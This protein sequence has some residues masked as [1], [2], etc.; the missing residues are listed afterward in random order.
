MPSSFVIGILFQD[1][2]LSYFPNLSSCTI[3]PFLEG[4]FNLTQEDCQ[5]YQALPVQI[6]QCSHPTILISPVPDE[7]SFLL[8]LILFLH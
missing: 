7:S 3:F 5:G 1:L 6:T 2:A 4:N 8:Y